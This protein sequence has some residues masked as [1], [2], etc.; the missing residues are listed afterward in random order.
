[1]ALLRTR[2]EPVYRHQLPV[3]PQG[4]VFQL[5]TEFAEGCVQDRSGQLGSRH[6]FNTKVFN[7]DQV[8]ASYKVRRYLVDEI[9]SLTSR[10]LVNPAPAAAWL[11]FCGGLPFSYGKA[12]VG[13]AAAAEQLYEQTWAPGWIRRWRRWQSR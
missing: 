11:S 13:H 2:E 7:A 8:K 12:P 5:P 4:F 6:P 10:L 3:I 9:I 1:V